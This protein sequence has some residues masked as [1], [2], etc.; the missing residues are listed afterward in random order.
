MYSDFMKLPFFDEDHGVLRSRVRAWVDA[1]LVR[2]GEHDDVE[3]A[4]RQIVRQLGAQEFL[5]F[6]VPSEYGGKRATIQARDLCILREELGRGSALAD[7][8]FALQALGA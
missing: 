8:M 7:T 6:A 2:S 5:G 3:D 4:S 1:N